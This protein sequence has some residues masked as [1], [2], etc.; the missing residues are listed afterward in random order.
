MPLFVGFLRAVP[1]DDNGRARAVGV[2]CHGPHPVLPNIRR[3]TFAR[4]FIDLLSTE[5]DLTAIGI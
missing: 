5:I 4:S 2:A 3:I 1:R